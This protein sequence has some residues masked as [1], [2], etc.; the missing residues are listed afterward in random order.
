MKIVKI[1]KGS[2]TKKS[3]SNS[4]L[5]Q[6]IFTLDNGQKIRK[7]CIYP[8]LDQAKKN[9]DIWKLNT[10][11]KIIKELE[12]KEP[13]HDGGYCYYLL[14]DWLDEKKNIEKLENVSIAH[15]EDRIYKDIIPFF[16]HA[17]PQE[18]D[19]RMIL[20][21][22]NTLNERGLSAETIHKDFAVL[23]N[24]FKK[25]VRDGVINSNPCQF[26]KKPKIVIQE[27]E[28]LTRD[29]IE[30]LLKSAKDY[31]KLKR[32]KNKNIFL[33]IKLALVSGC[34]RGELCGLLWDCVDFKTNTINIKY[35][36]E[37]VRGKLKLKAP[38]TDKA[39]KIAIPA[40]TM[41]L[42]KQHRKTRSKGE[43]VFCMWNDK[44][45]PQAPS[46]MG[47]NFETVRNMAGIKRATIHLL[48]HTHLSILAQSNIDIRTIAQRAGHH[49]I[50]T[51][52]RY[53]HS[54]AELDRQASNLF[55]DL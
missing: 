43:F 15:H 9:L 12:D 45:K 21:F 28:P 31:L 34:R 3:N 2:I 51:T 49:N 24:S 40:E 48:R 32:C 30:R 29:E 54:N 38:K 47:N 8:S 52:M 50:Q 46:S 11:E 53:C 7:S 35:S 27:K 25:L 13:L 41:M 4:Y 14:H 1:S 10:A 6:C 18:I 20:S 36:L 37:E 23:N 26:I 44:N 16:R 33:F 39:R 55:N 5:I 19:S 22:M 42:L 17:T